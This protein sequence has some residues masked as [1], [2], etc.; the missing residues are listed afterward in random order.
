MT[1]HTASGHDPKN[2]IPICVGV[3]TNVSVH[4]C[5]CVCVVSDQQFESSGYIPGQ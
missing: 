3:C 5:V 1:H 4:V 2:L